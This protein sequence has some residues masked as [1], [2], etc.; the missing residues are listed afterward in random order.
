MSAAVSQYNQ[1]KIHHHKLALWVGIA[2]IIMM[3]GA[4][5]S[6]Y[7]VRRASGNW[8][9]FKLPDIFFLNTLVILASSATLHWSYRSFING[10][11]KRYKALLAATLVFGLV[12]VLL[13][14]QGWKALDAMGA[15]FTVN[16]SSSFVYVIS[17]LH[18]AHVLGGVAA[19]VVALAHAFYLPFKPTPRRKLRFELV[20]QYWHF[21]DLLW[22]YLVIFFMLQS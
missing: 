17:G 16:P 11:E 10:A 20:V 19:L 12:F 6:A 5:T 18:A 22:V 14:Y 15:T 7:I 8:Y 2:T 9:E 4:F 21:V 1:N 13:Q 3:F